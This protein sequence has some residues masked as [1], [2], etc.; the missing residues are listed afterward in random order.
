MDIVL[1]SRGRVPLPTSLNIPTEVRA[2]QGITEVGPPRARCAAKRS[3]KCLE[4]SV[5]NAMILPVSRMILQ[6]NCSFGGLIL[7]MTELTNSK[8]E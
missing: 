2:D 1:A 8:T 3:S 7:T 6:K 5:L 4:I